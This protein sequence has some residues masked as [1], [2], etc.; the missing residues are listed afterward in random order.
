MKEIELYV[1]TCDGVDP[2]LIK[3]SEEATVEELIKKIQATGIAIGEPGEELLLLVENEEEP[4]GTGQ[5][6]CDRGVRHRHHVHCHRCRHVRVIVTYNSVDKEKTFS[7]SVLVKKVLKW[8]IDAFELK[9]ADADKVLYL[10]DTPNVEL[11][12]EAHIGSYAKHS[13]CEVK[14]CLAPP[15]RVQG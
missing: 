9:G 15:V 10:K 2:K 13:G 8:A 5:K 4:I 7:P 3:I 12:N 11:L 6:L 1:H 14:V